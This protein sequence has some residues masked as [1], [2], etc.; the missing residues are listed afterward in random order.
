MLRVLSQRLGRSTATVVRRGARGLASGPAAASA[1][2]ASSNTPYFVAAAGLSAIA[3]S[4]GLKDA[5]SPAS[6]AS[7][8][9]AAST[10][11]VVAVA[12]PEPVAAPAPAEPTPPPPAPPPPAP[13]ENVPYVIV[14][15]GTAA[16][17]AV[18][19]ILARDKAAKIVI[20]SAEPE[21]PYARTPLSKE[22]WFNPEPS[23][24][25]LIEK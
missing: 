22:L 9:A 4:L 2:Q 12:T 17:F 5:S 11:A 8:A 23:E 10:P 20:I 1:E 18:R 16:Y 14:G 3:L 25:W 7:Q 13:L 15:G 24:V 6:P 19:G 21:L